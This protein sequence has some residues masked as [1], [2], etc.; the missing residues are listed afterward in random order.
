MKRLMI[1][2]LM[3]LGIL[4]VAPAWSHHPAEGI[5]S[6]DIWQMVDGL[7]EDAD[8]PH[9][10]LDFDDVMDSM[11]VANV[12]GGGEDC[13]GNTDCGGRMLLVTSIVVPTDYADD[14]LIYVDFAVADT[15]RAP[16]GKTDSGTALIMEV[17][18]EDLEGGL[19]EISLYEPIGSGQS[20]VGV[21][22]KKGG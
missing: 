5:V 18:V 19:T 17:V 6:D 9:L 10:T 3:F 22:P 7:L 20:Q 8:S 4:C 14:Y 15:N 11:G 2:S 13:S 1:L 21:V 12:P 16:S